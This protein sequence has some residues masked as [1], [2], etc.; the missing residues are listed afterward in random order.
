MW[1]LV[2]SK[3]LR[4]RSSTIRYRELCLRSEKGLSHESPDESYVGPRQLLSLFEGTPGVILCLL[5]FA[6]FFSTQ[7]VFF[8]VI[9]FFDK[10]NKKP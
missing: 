8:S 6:A 4:R 2:F 7:E 10:Y 9:P 5:N 3:R 1:S